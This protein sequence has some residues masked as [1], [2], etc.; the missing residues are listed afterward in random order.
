M[1]S[2]DPSKVPVFILA[3]GLGT[4]ISEETALRPKPMIEIGGLPILLHIMKQY[5]HFGFEDFIICAGYLS[6]DIKD[7]F[8]NYAFRTNNLEIDHR[9]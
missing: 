1:S 2:I 9:Q 7:Y 3:G 5:R 4:R 8:L 6:W